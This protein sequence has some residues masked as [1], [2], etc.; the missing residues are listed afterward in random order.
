MAKY[1]NLPIYRKAME[2]LVYVEQ[3]V[4]DFPRYHKYATGARLRDPNFELT[5]LVVKA[6]NTF[7]GEH[8]GKSK[9]RHILVLADIT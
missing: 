7:L 9:P 5:S 1:E 3:T 6:N 4:R 8:T 2:L